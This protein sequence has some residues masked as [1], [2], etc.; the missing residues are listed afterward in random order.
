MEELIAD[1]HGENPELDFDTVY[2]CA[3]ASFEAGLVLALCRLRL[4]PFWEQMIIDWES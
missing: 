3:C 2:M 4:D 1:I